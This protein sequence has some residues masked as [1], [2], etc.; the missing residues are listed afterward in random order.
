MTKADS[1]LLALQYIPFFPDQP[2]SG[3]AP[4]ADTS[5]FHNTNSSAI[6]AGINATAHSKLYTASMY[7]SKVPSSR[8]SQRQAPKWAS[9]IYEYPVEA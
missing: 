7:F 8:M 9:Q 3:N 1:D 2:D 5:N 4:F 6:Y